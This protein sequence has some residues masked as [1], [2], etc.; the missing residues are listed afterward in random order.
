M[1]ALARGLGAA[2]FA[3]A[4]VMAS[5]APAPLSVAGRVE[6]PTTF[7]VADLQHMLPVVVDVDAGND[8]QPVGPHR[9][10]TGVMLWTLLD[11][12]KLVDE[13]GKK[14][15]MRH[16]FMASGA[17]GYTVAISIGEIAPLNEGKPV[18]VA[19]AQGGKP[20]DGLRLVI[21]GDK[22]SERF[23]KNLVSIDVR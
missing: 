3:L 5:A 1:R 18:L 7:S 19:Y 17:D 15:H 13:P 11:Q 21:P 20:M 2:L 23:V 4:P 12:A 9:S 16:V 22:R 14:T 6:H 8:K 10:F